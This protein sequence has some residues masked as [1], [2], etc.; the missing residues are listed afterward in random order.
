MVTLP[1]PPFPLRVTPKVALR[2]TLVLDGHVNCWIEA[3]HTLVCSQE[4][5]AGLAGGG[6]ADLPG[7]QATRP[8]DREG[9]K[10]RGAQGHGEKTGRG[11]CGG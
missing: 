7:H 4:T 3:D 2:S 6:R 9:P 1:P 10:Q 11:S 5:A 8:V